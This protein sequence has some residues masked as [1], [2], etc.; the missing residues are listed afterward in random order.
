MV[1]K[2]LGKGL[3]ALIPEPLVDESSVDASFKEIAIDQ[4]DRNPLQPRDQISPEGLSALR[5]SIQE[6]GVLQPILVRKV[7]ERYELIAG[8][9]RWTA[10][11]DAGLSMI[12]ARII[13][14]KT[15]TEI[16]E[17]SLV[18]NL[19]REDL[20]PMDVA[21]G[22]Q[23]LVKEFGLTHQDVARVV[24]TDR[25]TVTNLVRLLQLPEEIQAIIRK[26]EI[27]MGHAR[28]LLALPTPK[29]QVAILKK[30]INLGL[31]VRQVEALSRK[32]KPKNSKTSSAQKH[33][34]VL[35]D[36]EDRLR[37]IFGT[38]IRIQKK[39]E[40]GGITI[41]FFSD[42]EFN[43]ILELLESVNDNKI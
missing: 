23:R 10:A 16:L 25:S 36:I 9:R 38:K 39:N 11:K 7:G 30:I 21:Q 32:E 3:R 19:Q 4:I 8:E 35:L 20:N 6:Q 12:P 17:I 13:Q 22:Y 37:K 42:D 27:T 33:E 18:E 31:S 24:G 41:H 15:D 1:M 26:G 43:R 28:A 5:Q 40:Q 29:E 34:P 14:T 2:H